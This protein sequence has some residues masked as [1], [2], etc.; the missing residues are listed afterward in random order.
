MLQEYC[1]DLCA[2][3]KA[4]RIDPVSSALWHTKLDYITEHASV[5]GRVSR[6]HEEA[7]SLKLT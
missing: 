5:H 1:K 4:G 6:L 2:L 7:S 3:V